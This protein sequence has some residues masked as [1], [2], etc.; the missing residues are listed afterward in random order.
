MGCIILIGAQLGA[1]QPLA[2]SVLN[3]TYIMFCIVLFT[4]YSVI[5]IFPYCPTL[6]SGYLW[7]LRVPRCNLVR[8]FCS[9]GADMSSDSVFLPAAIIRHYITGVYRVSRCLSSF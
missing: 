4:S 7:Y 8:E 6:C 2:S 9:V 5:H 1:G 3:M